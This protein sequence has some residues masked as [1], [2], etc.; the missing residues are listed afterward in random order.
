MIHLILGCPTHTQGGDLGFAWHITCTSKQINTIS[1]L[2]TE[3][4][5]SF[6]PQGIPLLLQWREF[7]FIYQECHKKGLITEV[8]NMI[9]LRQVSTFIC[10]CDPLQSPRPTSTKIYWSS[11]NQPISTRVPGSIT[12]T[13]GI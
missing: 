11:Q 5:P 7:D 6:L 1:R 3:L 12:A 9:V 2:T 4:C 10:H 13:I 8:P